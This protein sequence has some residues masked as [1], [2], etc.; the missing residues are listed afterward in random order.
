MGIHTGFEFKRFG[1]VVGDVLDPSFLYRPQDCCIPSD[2]TAAFDRVSKQYLLS[3]LQAMGVGPT[4]LNFLDA[5]L[6]E[7]SGRVI[8]EGVASDPFAIFDT[9]FQGTVLGPPLWNA[10]FADVTVPAECFGGKAIV[11]AD[12]LNVF[13]QFDLEVPQEDMTN[14][15]NMCRSEVHKWGRVNRVSF[16]AAKEH[17]VSIHPILGQGDTFRLLGCM[18]DC[19]L[20][21][22]QA[23][24]TI[25]SQIR[26]KIHAILRTRNHYDVKSL[27]NQFKTHVWSLMEIHN[28][29]IFH[30]AGSYLS[31]VDEAQKK[32]LDEIGITEQEAF[33]NFNF[34]PPTLRRDIGILGLL[35]KRVLGKCHPIFQELLPF[36]QDYF[37]SLRPREHNKQLYD[38]ILEIQG[39]IPCTIIL[40]SRW[41]MCI[42]AFLKI[43]WTSIT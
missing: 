10:Y 7:R 33:L 8:V 35:H 34:A 3:K 23:I 9:V 32:F 41:S 5:Y 25:L 39:N 16:D 13:K 20:Q 1:Y 22:K 11:F 18:V 30:A 40:F 27:I 38:H 19:K 36:H 24:E 4:Y 2:I 31:R 29:A 42:T 17:I 26:P 14:E 15:M 21:M 6:E 12:D 43:M 37:G 28:G